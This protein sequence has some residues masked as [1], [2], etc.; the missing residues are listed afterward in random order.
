[1]LRNLFYRLPPSVRFLARRAI[2]LPIDFF[3]KIS[4][5]RSTLIPPRGL[6]FTGSGDFERSG[7]ELTRRFVEIGE[8]KSSD[9][10]LD[11]GSGIGRVAIP[12][13]RIL[14]KNGRYVGFDP[15]K[16]GINYC[17]K[18]ISRAFP[19]FQ[20]QYIP[21]LNDL[22]RKNG[23]NAAQF[24]FPY[25]N[26]Q[27]DFVCVNSVFTHMIDGEM[28]NYLSEIWRTMKKKGVCYATFFII[29]EKSRATMH[30]EFAFPFAEN[31]HFLMD[32]KVKSANVAFDETWLLAVLA[33]N[34]LKI[35]HRFDGFWA[36]RT[37][38]EHLDFQDVLFLEKI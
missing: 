27:F 38:S 10:F 30:P 34:G 18:N 20:F 37:A 14:D 17:Q 23:E 2:F 5:N 4:G 15:I 19:N 22:Y 36:G 31:N 28:E 3:E 32:K 29:N 25:E 12:L 11:V 6:I 8:L 33:K 24:R 26:E 16:I 21:L 7:I 13:T 9:S 35:R 1:M